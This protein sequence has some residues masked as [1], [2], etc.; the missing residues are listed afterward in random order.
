MEDNFNIILSS[1][2]QSF[3]N[4][5]KI[6]VFKTQ[7]AQR[8]NLIGDYEVGI[9]EIS[10]TY[11]WYNM[12]NDEY[13]SILYHDKNN[14]QQ[15]LHYT[16]DKGQF[17]NAAELIN[18]INNKIETQFS[19]L[20]LDE[21]PKVTYSS[22]DHMITID[23]GLKDNKLYCI[24]FSSDLCYMLGIE[25]KNLNEKIIKALKI[26]KAELLKHAKTPNEE[27]VRPKDS[28]LTYIS[29]H[30][31]DLSG[32]YHSL[33]VY[34]DIVKPSFVGNSLTQ[35]L[36]VVAVPNDYKFGQQVVISYTN[37]FYTPVLIKEFDTILID[38]KDSTKNNIPFKFGRVILTL[39]F[40]KINKN[41]SINF[42]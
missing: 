34:S 30:P 37:V 13:I 9:L 27:F 29:H 38:I 19:S 1:N 12:P 36:R 41:E 14:D 11:S 20:N 7:L 42:K 39:N 2:V 31:V 6:S 35:L 32:G 5:N 17:N 18:S 25:R 22:S 10:Y 15:I 28:F 26:E 21:N 3:F 16:F 24:T 33:F 4:E 40:R 8:I 23:H